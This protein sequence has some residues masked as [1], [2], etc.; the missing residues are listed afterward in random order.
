MNGWPLLNERPLELQKPGYVIY[1]KFFIVAITAGILLVAA[2]CG[3]SDS[4]EVSTEEP[5][6]YQIGSIS[7]DRKI[8]VGSSHSCTITDNAEVF[9]WGSGDSGE[10]G[11][12]K[13]YD[14]L[15]SSNIPVKVL[16]INNAVQVSAEDSHT[17]AL[18]D[19]GEISCWGR[20]WEG[21]LGDGKEYRLDSG[22][23]GVNTPVKVEGISNA[24]H[25]STGWTHT[26]ALHDTGEI[27]CW[28]EGFYGQLGDGKEYDEHYGVNVPGK[29][30]NIENAV[31]VISRANN[32][33]ALL[34][35]GE[36]WCWGEGFLGHLGD[37]QIYDEE[38]GSS[39]PVKV[40]SINNAVY[41]SA[42]GQICA[43]LENGEVWC[44]GPDLTRLT[45]FDPSDESGGDQ[46][47]SAG[48]LS[49]RNAPVRVADIDDA[50]QFSVG[51]SFICYSLKNGE[52]FCWGNG[53]SGQLGNG[54][55]Y[56]LGGGSDTPVKASDIN[57]AVQI[58]AGAFNACA[59]LENDEVW[60]WGLAGFGAG[61]GIGGM[62][63][64]GR[65]YDD[66][67]NPHSNVP[68]KVAN[69]G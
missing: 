32:T 31:Q 21:Q 7:P 38:Q 46:N 13:E 67:D 25:V 29:V 54:V 12:G 24:V 56:N 20:G 39:L 19:T 59:L 1:M 47:L 35:N 57:N 53:S 44:W 69:I 16:N 45:S 42:G 62:L 26:C 14:E 51:S 3:S 30:P 65:E 40:Q 48:S 6:G 10:L 8:S 52:V 63:G 66:T 50:L 43:L 37:G 33:C 22:G 9:C 41:I 68:V 18:H 28:G 55:N 60:C 58:S 4:A 61:F 49:K 36:V 64:D 2:S 15:G 11:D 17:C 27:S 23:L 34:E 5:T